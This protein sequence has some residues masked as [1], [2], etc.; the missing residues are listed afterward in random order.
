MKKIVTM[1]VL[2]ALALP[3]VVA[4]E[5]EEEGPQEKQKQNPEI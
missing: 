5:P 4:Q 3:A 2:L 1:V